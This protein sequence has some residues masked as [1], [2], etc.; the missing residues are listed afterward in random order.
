MLYHVGTQYIEKEA[1]MKSILGI[2]FLASTLTGCRHTKP[3]THVE[4]VDRGGEVVYVA[5]AAAPG[6]S[7]TS[8][9]RGA[10]KRSA[11]AI[12]L[13]FMQEH[14]KIADEVA[15]AVGVSD[16][17]IFLK[18]Y[19]STEAKNAALQDIDFNPGEHI[20]MATVQWTPP[21]FVKEAVLKFAQALKDKQIGTP[22]TNQSSGHPPAARHANE[23][24]AHSEI[25][26][27]GSDKRMIDPCQREQ[28]VLAKA[29]A[30]EQKVIDDLSECLRR[31]QG[32]RTICHR[33]VLYV[34][35]GT[36]K[37]ASA[38]ERLNS[39]RANSTPH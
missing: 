20:C 4:L 8:A 19:A 23:K 25:R 7:Q 38:Q 28:K 22:Q 5:G 21:I 18:R 32:D 11:E 3:G 1:M 13:R 35:A 10:V 26:E 33:Y 39:C 36:D 15:Q 27:G 17:S 24:P 16:G 2:L 31:T 12:A 6:L 37:S 30:A 34:E 9:C 14:E 29:K